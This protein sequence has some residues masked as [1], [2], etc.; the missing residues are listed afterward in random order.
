MP[1]T[2]HSGRGTP[3]SSAVESQKLLVFLGAVFAFILMF[4]GLAK[5]FPLLRTWIRIGSTQSAASKGLLSSTTPPPL[6][7]FRTMGR[8]FPSPAAL[9]AAG[10]AHMVFPR[11]PRPQNVRTGVIQYIKAAPSLQH[12]TAPRVYALLHRRRLQ[13]FVRPGPTP[14]RCVLTA[15]HTAHGTVLKSSVTLPVPMRTV[16]F[17]KP[18][19]AAVIFVR[20]FDHDRRHRTIEP[21]HAPHRPYPRQEE[22]ESEPRRVEIPCLDS[23]DAEQLYHAAERIVGAHP[24]ALPLPERAAPVH[25]QRT[26][27][28]VDTTLEFGLVHA[29][30]A[31]RSAPKVHPTT[32]RPLSVNGGNG[33]AIIKKMLKSAARRSKT[34]GRMQESGKENV[35]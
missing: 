3:G 19:P 11:K 12:M 6:Y 23:P 2:I 17:Q 7:T 1:S 15:T 8:G 24:A 25:P 32:T 14:L 21:L 16:Q 13:R 5:L 26:F 31:Q 34:A 9:A 27:P 35:A 28:W 33:N 22:E 29:P 10:L 18:A 30:F 20:T 4:F